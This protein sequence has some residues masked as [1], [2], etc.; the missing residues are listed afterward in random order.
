MEVNTMLPL[1]GVVLLVT[2]DLLVATVAGFA[3]GRRGRSPRLVVLCA[4]LLGLV[5]PLNVVYLAA[6]SLLPAGPGR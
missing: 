4:L 5:P 1:T 3:A 2:A 6:L